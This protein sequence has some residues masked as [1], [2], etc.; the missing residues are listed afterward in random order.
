MQLDEIVHQV[1]AEIA[2]KLARAVKHA[3]LRA[4]EG[5]LRLGGGVPLRAGRGDAGD[6]VEGEWKGAALQCQ[7]A[8][9]LQVGRA[10]SR[11][12]QGVAENSWKIVSG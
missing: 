11:V 3:P 5:E 8:G 7:L 12:G 4:V 10:G 9:E 6:G 1:H 2:E